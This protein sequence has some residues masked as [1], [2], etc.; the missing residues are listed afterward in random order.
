MERRPLGLQQLYPGKQAGHLGKLN[1]QESFIPDFIHQLALFV[2]CE[3][4]G[5]Y[6]NVLK[7]VMAEF[8]GKHDDKYPDRW[9]NPMPDDK[10]VLKEIFEPLERAEFLC[11]VPKVSKYSM[12]EWS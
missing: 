7:M 2:Y 6:V 9:T 12:P 1:R 3:Q 8:P 4:L 10:F 11:N 5:P